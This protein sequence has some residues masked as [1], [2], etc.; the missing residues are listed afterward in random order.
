M[1]RTDRRQFLHWTASASAIWSLGCAHRST[2]EAPVRAGDVASR[3]GPSI[4]FEVHGPE[5]GIPL[6]LGFPIMASYL[7][8]F[9]EVRGDVRSGYLEG[10]TDRYR[11][12]L[13]DYPNV[14]RTHGPEP[15]AMTADRVKALVCGTWPP[16]GA[17]YADMLRGV[18]ISVSDCGDDARS[19]S[20]STAHGPD[21]P[22]L[23]LGG[24]TPC[25]K[26]VPGAG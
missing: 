13:V 21:S 24:S 9:G 19:T 20:Q 6:F 4:H 16:L 3:P 10:L 1:K 15:D 5:D 17:P 18:R 12:L 23:S 2:R 11:V 25:P 14:G 8:I 7:D 26:V 22:P